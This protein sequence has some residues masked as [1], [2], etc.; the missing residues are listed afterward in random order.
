MRVVFPYNIFVASAGRRFRRKTL[1]VRLKAHR[2]REAGWWQFLYKSPVLPFFL[3]PKNHLTSALSNLLP[4]F[5]LALL[6]ESRI[7][8][9]VS[10]RDYHSVVIGLFEK[11]SPLGTPVRKTLIF[12]H[13]NC[14]TACLCL[15]RTFTGVP[16]AVLR[17]LCSQHQDERLSFFA[18][19][20]FFVLH[21]FP[22]RR[23]CGQAG[24]VC[25]K[26]EESSYW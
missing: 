8:T 2:N 4:D 10:Y 21:S 18:F 26:S 16:G 5:G 13:R 6:V 17:S 22:A 1:T 12:L 19:A 15:V 24:N 9:K 25:G 14:L 7:H 20:P 11:A 3:P 23:S